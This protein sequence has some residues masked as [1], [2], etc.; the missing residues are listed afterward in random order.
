MAKP[1]VPPGPITFE[2]E[3]PK[4]RL[5]VLR[6]QLRD[7]GQDPTLAEIDRAIQ[8]EAWGDV[9]RLLALVV[10]RISGCNDAAIRLIN[11]INR[12]RYNPL[13]EGLAD[14]ET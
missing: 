8:R 4:I 2:G 1:S 5:G 7:L 14:G 3:P 9:V 13:L 12:K 11:R 10:E 6:S